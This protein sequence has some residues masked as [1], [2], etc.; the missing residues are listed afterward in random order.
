MTG[1]GP[2]QVRLGHNWGLG[3]WGEAGG[4]PCPRPA[5]SPRA[6]QDVE[7]AFRAL[8][9]LFDGREHGEH[10]AGE[11][12]QEPGTREAPSAEAVKEPVSQDTE[13]QGSPQDPSH[14]LAH[15]PHLPGQP[16]NSESKGTGPASWTCKNRGR[17]PIGLPNTTLPCSRVLPQRR[18][19]NF[20]VFLLIQTFSHSQHRTLPVLGGPSCVTWCPGGGPVHGLPC[21]GCPVSS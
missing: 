7:R 4:M 21:A 1:W 20:S 19:R 5:P 6:H 11:D 12:Q 2:G 8:L 16:Q 3:C 14:T 15:A 17:T 13:A 9:V 18:G 10:E